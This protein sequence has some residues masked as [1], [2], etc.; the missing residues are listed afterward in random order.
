[1][2]PQERHK[3]YFLR[4]PVGESLYINYIKGKDNKWTI[5][6]KKLNFFLNF[7]YILSSCYIFIKQNLNYIKNV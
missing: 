1:M 6:I 5:K 7:L 2:A 3:N 4:R